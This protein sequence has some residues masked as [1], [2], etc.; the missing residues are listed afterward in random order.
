MTE[1]AK[2]RV[3]RSP[4]R[5]TK[6]H[7]FVTVKVRPGCVIDWTVIEDFIGKRWVVGYTIRDAETERIEGSSNDSR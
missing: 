1:E 5:Y 4:Y 3:E 2:G 7:D 6:T